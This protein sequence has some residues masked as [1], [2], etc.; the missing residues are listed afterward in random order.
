MRKHPY[1]VFHGWGLSNVLT[2]GFIDDKHLD[3]TKMVDLCGDM[4]KHRDLIA[5]NR[6]W[7]NL[8][9]DLNKWTK[10]A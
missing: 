2:F 7:I 6:L 8:P 3:S 9:R 5:E 1:L 4:K 10:D